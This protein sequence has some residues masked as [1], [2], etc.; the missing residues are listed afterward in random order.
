M[1]DSF[2]LTMEGLF[3]GVY[4]LCGN[5]SEDVLQP[6]MV[7]EAIY[8]AITL[9]RNEMSL[10][11]EGWSI[12][13]FVINA[14]ANQEEYLIAD[15]GFGRPY[16]A[17]TYDANNP[18]LRRREIK[19]ARM[20]DRNIEAHAVDTLGSSKHTAQVMFFYN[21]G[22]PE[23]KV[24]ISPIP[25]QSCAYRIWAETIITQEPRYA[26]V[27]AFLAHFFPLI[28][29]D[30]CI[31]VLPWCGFTVDDCRLKLE[32]RMMEQAKHYDIFERYIQEIYHSDTQVMKAANSSRRYGR[33]R[34]WG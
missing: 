15:P 10:T 17:E 12:S 20:Q 2:L 26:D 28:K 5:P 21:I 31:S 16:F 27:P 13:P 8:N 9:R 25:R 3:G 22:T 29:T 18:R 19:I 30:A 32:V 7:L 34:V 23:P 11:D 6:S 1:V 33:R 14:K 4:E 24:Q